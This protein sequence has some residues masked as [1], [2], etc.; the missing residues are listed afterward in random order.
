V[1]ETV[2]ASEN[3]DARRVPVVLVVDDSA[4]IRELVSVF[5]TDE[6]YRVETATDA[7]DAL[8]RFADIAPDVALV[9]IT[10]PGMSGV[11]LVQQ[12]RQMSSVPMIFLTAMAGTTSVV[13]GLDVGADDYITKPFHPDELAARVRAVLRRERPESSGPVT[14]WLGADLEVD[15]ERRL[16]RYRGD[17]VQLGRT[18]W[19]LLRELAVNAG[20]VCLNADLLRAVWGPEYVNDAQVLRICVSRLRRKL[21]ARAGETGPIRTYHN[22]GY[23]LEVDA[24]R[25]TS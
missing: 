24:P 13:S 18:E 8:E 11:Q 5:L 23:A 12:L 25:V 9:D 17:L 10:M 20:K 21:G 7:A 3:A 16:L 6:G 19:G 2:P 15:L 22:V 4:A 14:M 1:T